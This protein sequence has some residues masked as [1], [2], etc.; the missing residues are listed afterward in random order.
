MMD[1]DS[2]PRLMAGN[3]ARPTSVSQMPSPANRKICQKR[4]RSTYSQPWW[5]N[6]KFFA[7]PSF[8]ITASHWPVNAP[9]TMMNRQVNRTVHAEALVLRLVPGYR[10]ADVQAHAEPRG[11]DPQ[12]RELRV[13]GAAQR[14]RQVV[15]ECETV[16]LLA[17]DLVVRRDRTQQDLREEQRDHQPE[18][19]RR[20]ASS[21][22]SRAPSRA[23]RSA[24]SSGGGSSL[25]RAWCQPSKR[26][27]GDE[28]QHA[29]HR[30]HQQV[31]RRR[32]AH[33]RL[34]RPVV[35]VGNI[36]RPAV[37]V[38]AGP[39]RP[40]D[41]GRERAAMLGVVS[42]CR[43]SSR[44]PCAARAGAGRCRTRLVVAGHRRDGRCA[45]H[46][47]RDGAGGRIV[48]VGADQRLQSRAQLRP[49]DRPGVRRN[50][51]LSGGGP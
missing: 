35:G 3:K 5:P 32:I 18:I 45:L 14:I 51:A 24:G 12:H 2:P 6:Q 37:R 40:P 29:E 31:R 16:G 23:D 48:G 13:P 38:T 19:L 41:E 9:T 7:R 28:E 42:R 15:G 49:A 30:P 21:T 4:P 39:G 33:E 1:F 22:A 34:V 25:W 50:H 10:R 46:V 43:S 11:R 36:A 8:C 44:R 27:A 17:F 20:G 26:D 47:E